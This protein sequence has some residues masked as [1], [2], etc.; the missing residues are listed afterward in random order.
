MDEDTVLAALAPRLRWFVAVGRAEHVTHAADDLGVPQSTLSRGIARLEAEIGTPLFARSGRSV[1]LTREGRALLRHAE[2]ALAEL[3]TGAHELAGDVD[4]VRGRVTLAFLPTLG[5]EVVPRLVREFRAVR[6]GIRFDLLQAPH[7]TLL[8]WVREGDADL[9][10]TSPLPDEAAFA[11]DPLGEEE[12]RLAVPADH[13]LA[14]APAVAL[15]DAAGERF[16]GYLPG[17]GLRASIDR[18]CREAGFTPRLAFESADSATVRGFVGAGL[19]VALVPVSH[20][21]PPPGVVELPVTSPRTVRVIGLVRSRE[22]R[23][24]APARALREFVLG[25]SAPLFAT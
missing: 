18:W 10:L 8:Q 5:T 23:T 20:H 24:G 9:A 14:A 7:H 17:N 1:R 13:P 11:A 3:A 22:R 4:G 12:L 25:R 16:V 21:G 19:G 2:R 6:P 15:G